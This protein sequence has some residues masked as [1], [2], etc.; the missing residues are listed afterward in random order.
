MIAFITFNSSLVPLIEGQCSSNPWEFEFSSLR[1][2]QTDDLVILLSWCVILCNLKMSPINSNLEKQLPPVCL[3]LSLSLSL[4]SLSRTLS[5]SLSLCMCRALYLSLP[6]ALSSFF[7]RAS[8]R[9]CSRYYQQRNQMIQLTAKPTAA[10]LFCLKL[11]NWGL[12]K[13][14]QKSPKGDKNWDL[15]LTLSN[16]I[17]V[18]RPLDV[19]S[20]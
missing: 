6:V 11:K 18:G 17:Q 13:I 12:A 4:S 16:P 3:S 9:R 7:R 2:N 14:R 8:A 20:P 10:K 19:D 1:R 5:L 15:A